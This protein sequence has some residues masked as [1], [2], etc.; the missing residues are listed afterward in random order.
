L[1]LIWRRRFG[2]SRV[3][4]ERALR[5]M[6]EAMVARWRTSTDEKGS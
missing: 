6:L 1:T 5:E 4:A 3:T 2:M